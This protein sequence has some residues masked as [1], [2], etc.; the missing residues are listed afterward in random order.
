MYCTVYI[1]C[2][3]WGY[4]S[5]GGASRKLIFSNSDII[6]SLY[7]FNVQ[8]LVTVIKKVFKALATSVVSFNFSTF[9]MKLEPVPLNVVC[10]SIYIT[11]HIIFILLLDFALLYCS[12]ATVYCIVVLV[13]CSVAMSTVVLLRS[14][15]VL[16]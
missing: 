2:S 7:S 1:S 14:T 4:C 16:F 9:T 15:V 3:D 13:Y 5:A 10:L 12:V 8:L 6:S 11:L